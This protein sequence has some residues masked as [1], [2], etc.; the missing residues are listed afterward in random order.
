MKRRVL[1]VLLIVALLIPVA[2]QA[3]TPRA[4]YAYPDIT[5][6]GT[7]AICSS[8]ITAVNPTDRIT[9]TMSL[10]DG[11]YKMISWSA[12]GVGYVEFSHSKAVESGTT[13]K[14]NL[15]FS[16]NGVQQ[17]AVEIQKTCP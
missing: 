16:I 13:Y 10:Y 2:A 3:V 11:T 17:P 9:A 1:C 8:Q 12:S 4:P 15:R 6:N 7:T 5:F 14:L